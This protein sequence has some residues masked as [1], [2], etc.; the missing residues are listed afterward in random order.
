[1]SC[2]DDLQCTQNRSLLITHTLSLSLS[3]SYSHVLLVERRQFNIFSNW[4]VTLMFSN[5]KIILALISHVSVNR[6]L[7]TTG[8]AQIHFLNVLKS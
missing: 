4:L 8:L 6:R 1:M 5:S 2:W 7:D 3:V